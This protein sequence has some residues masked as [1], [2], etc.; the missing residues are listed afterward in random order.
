MSTSKPSKRE[1]TSRVDLNIDIWCNEYFNINK[2]K[3]D[4]GK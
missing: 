1:A 4:N 2:N 3:Q